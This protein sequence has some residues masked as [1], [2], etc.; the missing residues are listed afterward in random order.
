MNV[1]EALRQARRLLPQ[2][3]DEPELEAELLLRHCLGVDRA[4]LYRLLTAELSEEEQ[5]RFRDLVRR[6]LIHEPTAYIIGH[7]EF[8]GLDFEVTPVAIIP[9]PE[10]EVLV[11]L[12]IEAAH[13]KLLADAL[14]IADVGTGSGAIAVALASAL[15]EGKITATDTSPEA[16]ELAQRNAA[17]HR[18][19]KRIRF[20]QSDLLDTVPG[21]VDV[22]VANLPYVTTADWK[23]LPPEIKDHEPREGLDGG[24]DGLRVIERLLEQAPARLSPSGVLLAEIGDMQGRAAKAAARAAFPEAAVKVMPDPSGRDR[25]LAVH[26]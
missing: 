21:R 3:S 11:E 18:V 6:R 4:S 25:V 16:L 23:A 13:K 19:D 24:P 10:T 7:K 5:Q 8:F 15:P 14:P 22:L 26:T 12:A 17:R 2:V 9:R 1:L 20:L